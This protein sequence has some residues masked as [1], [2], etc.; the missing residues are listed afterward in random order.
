MED[1]ATLLEL[2]AAP[3]MIELDGWNEALFEDLGRRFPETPIGLRQGF[4]T[5]E[6]L[7]QQHRSGVRVFHLVAD[8]HGVGR[9]GQFILDL[10]RQA[11]AF[12]V[13]AG[14]RDE[15]T[16]LGSGGIIAGEHVP[17]AIIC[18]LDAVALDTP[19]WAALQAEF[20]GECADRETSRFR[21]PAKLPADW[22][23]RRLTNLL[24]SWHDQLLEVLGAM[25]LREVRRLRGEMG[26]AM[27][28][29]DLEREAFSG[30]EGYDD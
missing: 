16:L 26:R 19:L 15:V 8:Y 11:H 27:F 3:P 23:V 28:Q 30:I 22:G 21:L 10:I 12:F 17:K 7:S 5:K 24:A 13:A 1:R 25:G 4:V 2:R 9:D 20:L 14:C 6:E 18:G 29:K